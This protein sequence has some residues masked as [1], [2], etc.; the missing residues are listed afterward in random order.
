MRE[1]LVSSE[2]SMK[3]RHLLEKETT[4]YTGELSLRQS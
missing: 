3:H 4:I 2:V 1:I